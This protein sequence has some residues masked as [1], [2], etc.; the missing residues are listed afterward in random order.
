MI[1]YLFEGMSLLSFIEIFELIFQLCFVLACHD[2]DK[3]QINLSDNQVKITNDKDSPQLPVMA[4]STVYDMQLDR[5]LKNNM[6]N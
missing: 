5:I 3:V 1:V 6:K 2:D 4:D